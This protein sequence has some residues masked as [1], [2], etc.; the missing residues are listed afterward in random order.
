MPIAKYTAAKGLH[1]LTDGSSGFIVDGAGLKIQDQTL[2]FDNIKYT[3]TFT[4]LT[5]VNDKIDGGETTLYHNQT[6]VLYD[7]DANA[8]T[9]EFNHALENNGSGSGLAPNGG[10]GTAIAIAEG[11]DDAAIMGAVATAVDGHGGGDVFDVEIAATGATEVL[12]VWVKKPGALDD[13]S[14]AIV[15]AQAP[16]DTIATGATTLGFAV[17]DQGTASYNSTSASTVGN[18]P[19]TQNAVH[20]SGW[21]N[22][23]SSYDDSDLTII[24]A[25]PSGSDIGQEKFIQYNN[26]SS[27]LRLTGAFLAVD[28]TTAGTKLTFAAG[29]NHWARLIWNGTRWK[30]IHGS[31]TN[32]SAIVV[33]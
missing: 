1:E 10:A 14:K 29:S 11:N 7:A 8:V 17:S 25:F 3:L 26:S 23:T 30:I 33:A 24:S 5:T 16:L 18:T 21:S 31:N 15:E 9:F 32:N 22:I 4:G 20:I 28:G 13:S 2:V 12:T 19:G 27:P 6:F